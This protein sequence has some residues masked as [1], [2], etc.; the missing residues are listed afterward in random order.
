M[1]MF[2]KRET[3]V[4]LYH[5]IKSGYAVFPQL[6][7]GPELQQKEILNTFWWFYSEAGPTVN[8]P[9][10]SEYSITRDHYRFVVRMDGVHH[11]YVL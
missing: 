1:R 10:V 3:L 11:L 8:T 7:P 6:R 4:M 2:A 9:G 5:N